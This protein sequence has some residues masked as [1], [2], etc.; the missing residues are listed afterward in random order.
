MNKIVRNVILIV[1]FFFTSEGLWASAPASGSITAT[2]AC[3]AFASKNKRT[4]PG[5]IKL[6]ISQQYSVFEVNKARNPTW[7]RVR[8]ADASPAERWI[9]K[10][11]GTGDITIGNG[12]GPGGGNVGQGNACTTPGL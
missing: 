12:S 1:V 5:D 2:Q 9:A 10:D 4:N 3:D 7:Y 6:V 11:C 8:V